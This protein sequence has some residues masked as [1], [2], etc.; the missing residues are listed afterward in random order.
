M[1]NH[2]QPNFILI[3]GE[4]TGRH[5]GC[6]GDSAA[7]TPNL[8]RL[9]AEGC[10]YD[11][12]F[13]TYP[14]CAPAR[15]TLVTGQYPM[16]IGT[17]HMRST[18]LNPPRL[19]THELRDVGYY[20]SW[21][22]KLDFNFDPGE[23]WRDDH[24]PWLER[25]RQGDLPDQPWFLY[26]N[27]IGTH[28]SWM[29]PP[30]AENPGRILPAGMKS[31]AE[32]PPRQHDPAAVRVPAYLPDT[33]AVRADIA[34]HHDNTAELD[35]RVGRILEALERSGQADRTIV[36]FLADHGRGLPREKRWPYN[37][38]LQMPLLM[39]GPG[40]EP[41][42]TESRLVSWVDV[43]PTI[44]SLAG[45]PTPDQYDGQVFRGP[46]AAEPRRYVFGGRD[47]MDE[48]FDRVRIVRDQ[49]YHYVRN[50]HPQVPYAQ[51]IRFMEIMPTMKELRQLHAAGKL[52]DDAAVFMRNSKPAEELY[53]IRRDPDCVK[54]LADHPE[55]ADV[56]QQMRSALEN[57]L[58]SFD[59]LGAVPERDLVER[60]LVADRIQE[61]RDRVEPLPAEHR[62]G[63]ITTITEMHE[64]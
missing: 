32:R 43:P 47:R 24:E 21:P 1:T 39:R 56:C 7:T 11:Q 60:G 51:R 58:D 54:N 2:Q 16:K 59:D 36:I 41:G 8:D 22:T 44:L 27:I 46:A 26:T 42:A 50:F 4:D 10:R 18:L 5:L 55:H 34:R 29:W 19:F 37:A 6:Y 57:W 45:V 13:T 48:A 49:N 31:E 63:G 3:I 25:L 35:R 38:G 23:G 15:S 12:A 64:A 20:V 30:H 61:Y 40:I 17:H 62:I 33:P 52:A 28:E 14:V 53:D 9:A